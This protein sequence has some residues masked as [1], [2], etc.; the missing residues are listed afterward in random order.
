MS[1]QDIIAGSMGKALKKG[2]KN[3]MDWCCENIYLEGKPFSFQGHA[4]LKELYSSHHHHEVFQK[5]AQTGISTRVLLKS[6]WAGDMQPLK[7]IYF[8]PTDGD[9]EDFSDDRVKKVL[10]ESPYLNNKIKGTDNKGLKQI[11]LSSLYFRGMF[12]KKDVKSVNGDIVVLDELD[13]CSQENKEFAFDRVMHSSLGWKMELSQ[14]SLPGY[15]INESFD[16]TDQRFWL[17]KCPACNNWCNVVDYFPTCLVFENGKYFLGCSKCGG[18]LDTQSG[19]WVAKFPTKTDSRGYLVSG[20]YSSIKPEGMSN[21]QEYAYKEWKKAKNSRKKKRVAISIAGLTFAG[22]EQP[23]ND[24]NM[25]P[26]F[27]SHPMSPVFREDQSFMGVDVGDMLHITV[28]HLCSNFKKIIHYFE[29][30][31]DWHRLDELMVQHDVATCVIDA[32]PYKNSA[33]N[34]ARRW[35]EQVYIQYFKGDSR[36]IGFEGDDEFAVPKITDDRTESLDEFIEELKTG[37]MILP[38]RSTSETVELAIKHFKKL[39]KHKIEKDDGSVR[40]IYKKMGEDH[41]A[42]SANSFR[43]ACELGIEQY[44]NVVFPSQGSLNA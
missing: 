28:G 30:T 36:K 13:E 3:F 1:L 12:T 2:D 41:F 5:A 39:I 19:E 25:A 10:S 24:A 4:Y 33:K 16:E 14:P 6:F 38:D 42:F 8:F 21:F 32:M 22:M 43:I 37:E 27:G 40:Y 7:V 15:A 18:A 20:L 44:G 9:V 34:F 17:L 26:A 31:E 35:P 11:G 23:L 29:A